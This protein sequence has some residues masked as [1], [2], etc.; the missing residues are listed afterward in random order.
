MI[1]PNESE[2]SSVP[3][4]NL[5]PSLEIHAIHTAC[6]SHADAQNGMPVWSV[7]VANSAS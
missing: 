5:P 7:I 4:S 3:M 6:S 1:G 2:W